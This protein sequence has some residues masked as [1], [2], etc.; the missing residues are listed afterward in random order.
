MTYAVIL[1]TIHIFY[2][3]RIKSEP[4]DKKEFCRSIAPKKLL[5]KIKPKFFSVLGPKCLVG[6]M[7][8]WRW[9]D[10]SRLMMERE[11]VKSVR[12]PA[13]GW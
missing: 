11:N 3:K 2:I 6:W 8:W 7:G 9:W 12:A 10:Q 13:A 5:R 1:C 4:T